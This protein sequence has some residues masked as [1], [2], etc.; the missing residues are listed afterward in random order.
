MKS[1]VAVAVWKK[2][3]HKGFLQVRDVSGEVRQCLCFVH[4]AGVMV[5]ASMESS[6]VVFLASWDK[7]NIEGT[8][9][10]AAM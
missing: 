8:V 10:T 3:R 5:W 9:G 4:G 1:A 7:S 6:V 2:R